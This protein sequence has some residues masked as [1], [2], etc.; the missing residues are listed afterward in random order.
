M[1]LIFLLLFLNMPGKARAIS[2]EQSEAFAATTADAD[3][4]DEEE[5]NWFQ[6]I[7]DSVNEVMKPVNEIIKAVKDI[8]TNGVSYIL[9]LTIGSILQGAY[10][11]VVEGM[12]RWVF[13]TPKLINFAWV[14]KLWWVCYILGTVALVMGMLFTAWSI[15]AGKKK[16]FEQKGREFNPSGMLVTLIVAFIGITF[17]LF[18]ADTIITAE[19]K[20]LN[21]IASNT[22]YEQYEKHREGMAA[23][24]INDNLTKEETGFDSFSGDTLCRMAYGLDLNPSQ[25]ITG[26]FIKQSGFSVLIPMSLA[27]VVLILIGVFGLLRFFVIGIL[28]AASPFWFSYCAFSGDTDPAW[29]WVNLFARSVALSF[30]FDMAW[31]FSVYVNINIEENFFGSGQLIASLLFLLALVIAIKFWFKWVIKAVMNPVKLAGAEARMRW[32][33][34]SEGI[35][36]GMQKMGARYG[37]GELGYMGGQMAAAGKAYQQIAKETKEDNYDWEKGSVKDRLLD[38]KQRYENDY[39]RQYGTEGYMNPKG[40]VTVENE[41]TLMQLNAVGLD[42]GEVYNIL[43]KGGLGE[44]AF[45]TEDG[46]VMV[47]AEHMEQAK[48]A[49]RNSFE[50]AH[51]EENSIIGDDIGFKVKGIEDTSKIETL[52]NDNKIRYKELRKDSHSITLEKKQIE[53]LIDWVKIGK[54][55]HPENFAEQAKYEKYDSLLKKFVPGAKGIY[56][57]M[58][59]DGNEYIEAKKMLDKL[60][61]DYKVDSKTNSELWVDNSYRDIFME[62]LANEDDSNSLDFEESKEY[63]YFKVNSKDLKGLKDEINSQFPDSAFIAGSCIAVEK[64]DEKDERINRLIQAYF[65]KTPYWED[66]KG[67]YWYKD[68]SVRRIVPHMTKPER[69][70]RYMGKR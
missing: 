60:A 14:K 12:A 18:I 59:D 27:M 19:N 24:G 5:R 61:V 4:D 34:A 47:D 58:L 23:I 26:S 31:L 11:Q 25:S 1:A 2:N 54:E 49:V 29:G 20:M 3:T 6:K 28:G 17:S 8:L 38:A 40:S 39:V 16:R 69:G 70:G 56:N 68:S 9:D 10:S 52:L 36:R 30:F 67:R 63:V 15:V 7:G 22:L 45:K 53:Q 33:S 37:L 65:K 13:L 44:V 46:R 62:N 64:D 42:T 57:Y 48:Q 41:G 35:G 50:E 66:N 21:S 32:G 43:N 51:I 55:I